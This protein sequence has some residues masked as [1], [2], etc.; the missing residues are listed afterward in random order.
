[1]VTPLNVAAA[2]FFSF[3]FPSPYTVLTAKIAAVMRCLSAGSETAFL[4][5]FDADAA[6]LALAEDFRTRLPDEVLLGVVGRLSTFFIV[7][8]DLDLMGV[9]VADLGLDLDR[10]LF[11]RED[12]LTGEGFINSSFAGLA[13]AAAAAAASAC[14]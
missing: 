3:S 5:F 11:L 6:L 4:F 9:L 13:M 12:D 1:M 14:C 7:T 8:G 10:E 2:N